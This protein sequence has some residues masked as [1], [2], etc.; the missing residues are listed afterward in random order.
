MDDE[1]PDHA[2]GRPAG[3]RVVVPLVDVFRDDD[4]DD[5]VARRHADGADGEDGF[6]ADAVNPEDRGDRRDEHHDAD[7]AGGEEGGGVFAEAELVEDGG[8]V[9]KHGVDARP[10]GVLLVKKNEGCGERGVGLPAGRT[11]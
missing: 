9:V 1:Q 8:G 4:G 2:H 10:L 11:W 7:D 3:R 5:D 6:A